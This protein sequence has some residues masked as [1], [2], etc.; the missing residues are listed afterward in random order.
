MVCALGLQASNPRVFPRDLRHPVAMAVPLGFLLAS[1]LT[2]QAEPA[3][4]PTLDLRTELGS[5]SASRIQLAPRGC[6]EGLMLGTVARKAATAGRTGQATVEVWDL[7]PPASPR[8][9][10]FALYLT[11]LRERLSKAWLAPPPSHGFIELGEFMLSDPSSPQTLDLTKVK[12][13]Q[14]RFNQMPPN[15][16]PV[17]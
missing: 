12:S 4:Q 10:A 9:E 8:R 17:Q 15:G 1:L 5:D 14:D 6:F 7:L 3:F 13:M 16:S 2:T 11:S